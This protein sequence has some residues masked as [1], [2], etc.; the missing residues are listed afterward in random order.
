[1]PVNKLDSGSRS[2]GSRPGR[3][4]VLCS[5][6]N[7]SLSKCLSP[8]RSSSEQSGKPNEVRWIDKGEGEG[9]GQGQGGVILL[10]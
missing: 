1:M 9:E 6:A 2:L 10:R 5:W 8:S 7:S 3:V 4:N